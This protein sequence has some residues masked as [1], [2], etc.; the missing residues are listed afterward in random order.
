[1]IAAE[2]IAAIM[3][4]NHNIKSLRDL[5]LLITKGLPKASI[6]TML[7]RVA[8][9]DSGA[10]ELRLKII[11]KTTYKRR[12]R[13]LKPSESAAVERLAR[14]IA[15]AEYVWDDAMDARDFL[16]RPHPM[17]SGKSPIESALTELGARE[18]EEL[19]WSLYTGQP[20]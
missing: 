1:M 3:G 6:N 10:R 20:V 7:R 14:V 2:R 4:I 18:V 8:L 9:T 13:L 19:L 15:T 17:L 12:K 5:T 16:N 11:S